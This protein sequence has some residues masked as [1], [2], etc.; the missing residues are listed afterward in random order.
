MGLKQLFETFVLS[1]GKMGEMGDREIGGIKR[2]FS[3]FPA[4]IRE[5]SRG[6]G[7]E[8]DFAQ[9]MGKADPGQAP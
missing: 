6:F 8:E 2:A 3:L 5:K 4:F 9:S 7:G 1:S